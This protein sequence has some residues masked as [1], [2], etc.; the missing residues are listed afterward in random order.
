MRRTLLS[1]N[2]RN[3]R[4][5]IV[6]RDFGNP[7]QTSDAAQVNVEVFRNLNEPRFER[8]EYPVT[9]PQTTDV[10]STIVQVRAGDSDPREQFGDVKYRVLGDDS[11]PNFFAVDETSGDVTLQTSVADDTETTYR[12]ND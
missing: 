8:D 7:P 6:A 11:A 2:A 12:V 5:R 4:L 10:T 3:Y 1:D 9:I